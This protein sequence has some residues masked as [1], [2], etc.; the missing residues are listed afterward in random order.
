[1]Q[2]WILIDDSHPRFN[3]W[4]HRN[5]YKETFWKKENPNSALVK[6]GSDHCTGYRREYKGVDIK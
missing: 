3:T 4:E 2:E 5:G 1:M 6:T